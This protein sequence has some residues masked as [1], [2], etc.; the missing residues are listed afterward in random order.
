MGERNFLIFYFVLFSLSFLFL[1]SSHFYSWAVAGYQ[2]FLS[3]TKGI[4]VRAI[5]ALFG[6]IIGI[7]IPLTLLRKLKFFVIWVLLF[8]LILP[9]I[10]GFEIKE[11]YRWIRIGYFTL[12]PFEFFRLA[13]LLVLASVFSMKVFD[14]RKFIYYV[15]WFL[16]S[17]GILISQPHY[18]AIFSLIFVLFFIAFLKGVN[19]KYLVLF[20]FIPFI[21]LG[22]AKITNNRYVL[23]RIEKFIKGKEHYQ[24]R[25]AKIAISRGALFG[26]GI[27]KGKIKYKYLPDLNRDFMFALV[28]EEAGALGVSILIFLYL[29]IIY[30]LINGSLKVPDPFWSIFLQGVALFTFFNVSVHIATNMGLVPVTG[31]TLPFLSFGGSSSFSF[32]LLYGISY[33]ILSKKT[34]FKVEELNKEPCLRF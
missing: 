7:V 22:F 26:V 21:I 33:K 13:F 14:K 5:F 10:M 15:I 9:R 24:V 30:V 8:F 6:F 31:V 20:I 25:Q 11:T 27:G 29:S 16:I 32:S 18:S 1:F 4:L 12:Q 34:E 2:D 3:V 17:I 23:S 19:L 28:A